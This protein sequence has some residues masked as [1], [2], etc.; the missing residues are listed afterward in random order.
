MGG[1]SGPGSDTA[2]RSALVGGRKR[3]AS[4]LWFVSIHQGP[5]RCLATTRS[6]GFSVGSRGTGLERPVDTRIVMRV[7]APARASCRQTSRRGFPDFND[8]SSI[9]GTAGPLV[10]RGRRLLHFVCVQL[11][12]VR[13]RCK[14]PRG[15]ARRRRHAAGRDRSRRDVTGRH[16][17]ADFAKQSIR[18]AS[19]VFRLS[20]TVHDFDS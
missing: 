2:G 14:L 7:R 19:I 16:R 9:A 12:W 15:A 1:R 18:I 3:L 13:R 17:T 11:G 10:G 6:A 5:F 4:R 8:A 20:A